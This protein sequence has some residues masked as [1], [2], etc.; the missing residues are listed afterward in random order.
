MAESSTDPSRNVLLGSLRGA[1]VV[2][3]AAARAAALQAAI[4]GTVSHHQRPAELAC[5][6]ISQTHDL[7]ESFGGIA[8]L[9]HRLFSVRQFEKDPLLALQESKFEPAK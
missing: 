4:A 8:D 1:P 7:T 6:C 5:R 9:S 3:G 2:L